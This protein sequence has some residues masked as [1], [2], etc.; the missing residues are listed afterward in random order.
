MP[1]IEQVRA[2]LL[3]KPGS[4]LDQHKIDT[5]LKSLMGTKWFS[6]VT[7]YYSPDPGGQE[8]P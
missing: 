3:S 5:D 7:P 8:S 6:E 2:K 4:P 1:M